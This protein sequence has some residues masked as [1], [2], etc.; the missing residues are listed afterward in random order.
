MYTHSV[1]KSRENL[2]NFELLQPFSPLQSLSM[3][4]VPGNGTSLNLPVL[5]TVSFW[6]S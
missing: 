6:S 1:G 4:H 3:F 2:P 5:R